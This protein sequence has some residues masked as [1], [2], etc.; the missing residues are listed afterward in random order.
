MP[1]VR[2]GIDTDSKDDPSSSFTLEPL[3]TIVF[4]V[5]AIDDQTIDIGPIIHNGIDIQTGKP[6]AQTV[7][8]L[9]DALERIEDICDTRTPA[10]HPLRD[11]ARAALGKLKVGETS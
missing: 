11:I 8:E 9:T 4:T 10:L 1:S 2:I 3:D 6:E 7:R 5:R